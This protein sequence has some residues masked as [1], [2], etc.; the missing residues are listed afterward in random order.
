MIDPEGFLLTVR[1]DSVSPERVEGTVVAQRPHHP[2]P[3][4]R[5]V[6]AVANLPAPALELVLYL[7]RW[8]P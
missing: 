8:S 5:V 4:A 6:I 1:L 2:E 7:R 3:A